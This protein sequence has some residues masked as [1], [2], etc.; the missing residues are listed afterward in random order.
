MI[1]SHKPNKKQELIDPMNPMKSLKK[2]TG[3]S[4]FKIITEGVDEDSADQFA[5]LGG[6]E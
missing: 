5:A 4:A 6:S 2:L 3:N 1:Q